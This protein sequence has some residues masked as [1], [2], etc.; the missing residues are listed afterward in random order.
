[1]FST[2]VPSGLLILGVLVN[3]FRRKVVDSL[4]FSKLCFSLLN[5]GFGRMFQQSGL[6]AAFS[7]WFWV[8]CERFR[9]TTENKFSVYFLALALG[10]HH[11]HL[12]LAVGTT[13][14][15]CKMSMQLI[16]MVVM[17]ATI[18]SSTCT[19]THACITDNT[20]LYVAEP[21]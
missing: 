15:R 16:T 10:S 12:Q 9:G 1:V 19:Q 2:H 20:C 13:I 17:D 8:V 11:P 5:G 7:K 18:I 3:G 21:C 4:C 14:I 6:G